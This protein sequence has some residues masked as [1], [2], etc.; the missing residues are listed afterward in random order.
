MHLNVHIKYNHIE[1]TISLIFW[2]KSRVICCKLLRY[3]CFYLL[4]KPWF[5]FSTFT[6]RFSLQLRKK[7]VWYQSSHAHSNTSNL[8]NIFHSRCIF[9]QMYMYLDLAKWKFAVFVCGKI[10]GK[11]T[12]HIR[13]IK[14]HS[15]RQ[16]I[17]P[18]QCAWLWDLCSIVILALSVTNYQR[19]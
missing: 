17:S 13:S 19:G 1:R 4:L 9:I 2:F 8:C 10:S 12:C 3:L 6:L 14:G 18:D 16:T 7:Y 15:D 11:S 5:I